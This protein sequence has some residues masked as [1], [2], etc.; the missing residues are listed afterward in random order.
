MEE[1]EKRLSYSI[2]ENIRNSEGSEAAKK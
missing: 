1:E 2:K